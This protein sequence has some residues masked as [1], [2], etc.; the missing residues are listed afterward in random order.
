VEIV[1]ITIDSAA[2]EIMKCAIVFEDLINDWILDVKLKY[3]V[4]FVK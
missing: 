4:I 2:I 3:E 1:K